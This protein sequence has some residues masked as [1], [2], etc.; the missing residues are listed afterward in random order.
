MRRLSEAARTYSKA[1]ASGARPSETI[2]ELLYTS[3]WLLTLDAGLEG[4]PWYKHHIYA[5]GFYT[6]Y[7]LKTI[8][9]VREAIEQR[10]FA[11]VEPQVDIAARVLDGIAER[12]ETLTEMFQN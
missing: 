10:N 5:P 6:G 4:R 11:A 2:N 1:V 9:A 3:E 8:P 12:I 7:G